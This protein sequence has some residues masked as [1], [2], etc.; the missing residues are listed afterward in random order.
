M[1]KWLFWGGI[2]GMPGYAHHIDI[3]A[4]HPHVPC[5]Q[6][7]LP[8]AEYDHL[9]KVLD[10]EF[11]TTV[12]KTQ[13][14]WVAPLH[15]AVQFSVQKPKPRDFQEEQW[16]PQQCVQQLRYVRST[17][18]E[19]RVPVYSVHSRQPQAWLEDLPGAT[20]PTKYTTETILALPLQRGPCLLGS[21]EPRTA[22]VLPPAPMV[23][24]VKEKLLEFEHWFAQGGVASFTADLR[25]EFGGLDHKLRKN[26]FNSTMPTYA[27]LEDGAARQVVYGVPPPPPPGLVRTQFPGVEHP[28][29]A[30]LRWAAHVRH[31]VDEAT[32]LRHMVTAMA[33][34]IANTHDPQFPHRDFPPDFL[35]SGQFAWS[36]FS[37]VTMDLD[38]LDGTESTFVYGS[39]RCT[40]DPWHEV[41]MGM[42]RNDLWII[43]SLL[44]HWGGGG[45]PKALEVVGERGMRAHV[46]IK[47]LLRSFA[48]MYS[49]WR[50]KEYLTP[51]QVAQAQAHARQ[52][53]ECWSAFG[54]KPTPWAHWAACHS[55]KILGMYRSLYLFSSIPIE[56]GNRTFKVRLKNSMRGWCLKKPRVTRRGMAQVVN[57]DA[58]AVGVQLRKAKGG[59]GEA[60][61]ARK[62]RR[63]E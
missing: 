35:P 13:K 42:R 4:R 46:L 27:R 11:T 38:V 5:F 37:P 21:D 33:Y 50:E 8:F 24:Q 36:A 56:Y 29:P 20:T 30:L 40:P 54:W 53:G 22:I 52:F 57:T 17:D 19:E 23:N 62:R 48:R 55:G 39:T 51:T 63:A 28:L 26:I 14:L 59:Q 6:I 43:H 1:P 16:C 15:G 18:C 34:I 31:Q 3:A 7:R 25:S 2:L 45:I 9:T 58:L 60:L 44:V 32:Q 10:K 41:R 47:L 12:N 61:L 49:L